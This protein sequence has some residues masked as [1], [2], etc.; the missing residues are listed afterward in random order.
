N[1]TT[2]RYPYGIFHPHEDKH[3][4]KKENIGLIEAIGLA[5]L[6]SRLISAIEGLK[7]AYFNQKPLSDDL[8]IYQELFY[9][10]QQNHILTLNNFDEIIE[11]EI[12]R[13]FE[14]VLLDCGVFKSENMN[15]FRKFIED[16]IQ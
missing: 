14:N 4:I 10:I 1:R 12:G 6:P 11:N 13:V 9:H 15:D 7:V 8:R 3:H 16:I 2:V 5:I